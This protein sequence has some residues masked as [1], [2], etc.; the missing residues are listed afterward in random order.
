M[1]KIKTSQISRAVADLSIRANYELSS[2]VLGALKAALRRE[3]NKNG[4]DI[5]AQLIEN[6]KIARREKIPICQDTGY[7]VIFVEIG[8]N[9]QIAG[10]SLEKAINDGVKQGYQKGYLRKS[11]VKHPL[12][13]QNTKTNTPA[14][15]HLD[16]VP[17]NKIKIKLMAKGGGAENC[18]KTKVFKPTAAP[19]EIIKFV[20][21]TVKAAGASA[22]PPL[23]IG[24]G[25]GGTF[26]KAVFLAKKSLFRKI[27]SVARDK[28]AARLEKDLLSTINKTGIGPSGLGG[29]T[30]ALAVFVETF[31][32]HIASLPVAVNIECHA[33][34]VKEAII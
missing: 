15:I 24:V 30:T 19:D 14:H 8:Q 7:A 5:L 20:V 9:V 34:R 3:T 28:I 2:D 27:G 1:R 33:H 31:P 32:C 22:C 21:E 25:M 17:G 26:D 11:I 10:G 12:D 6:A 4:K 18:S 16:L 23:I 29:K 13:R